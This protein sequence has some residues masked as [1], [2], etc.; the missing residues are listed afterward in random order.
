MFEDDSKRV[1]RSV[2]VEDGHF[3]HLTEFPDGT[4]VCIDVECDQAPDYVPQ[5]GA[6]PFSVAMSSL[7]SMADALPE[8]IRVCQIIQTLYNYA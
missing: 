2:H 6:V 7:A 8:I 4:S 1:L 3:K 5:P